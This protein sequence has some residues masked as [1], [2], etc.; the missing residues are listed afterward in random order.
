MESDEKRKIGFACAYTPMVLIDAAG[1]QPYRILPLGE[2]PDQ[3]GRLLHDNLCPHVKRL[4][5]RAMAGELPPLEGMLFMNSCDAMRRLADVWTR[6]R[7]EQS[8]LIDL[9]MSPDE[10]SV[11]FFAGELRRLR[12]I[13][14][15]WSGRIMSDED[16]RHSIIRYNELAA[17]FGKLREKRMALP[18]GASTL[19]KLYT[20]AVTEPIEELLDELQGLLDEPAEVGEL[21]DDAVPLYL[22]GNVLPDSEAFSLF[23]NCGARLVADDLCSG[24][25]QFTTI[26]LTDDSDLMQQLALDLLNGPACARTID[27]RNPG[28][29]AKDVLEAAQACGARGVIGHTVKFC[30]PY[31]ARFPSVRDTLRE[32]D[33]PFLMLEG[34]CSLRSIGQQRTRIEAFVEMLR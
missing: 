31:L 10:R 1:F 4:L 14:D 15:A 34:D 3:A 13:L 19:Q 5:D 28:S 29:M 32:A 20:R 16:I 7:E 30:D 11:E 24:S 17:L 22:F 27:P 18:G 26:S 25:R 21:N 8:N 23:E 6:L 33:L 2:P 9:P 12:K